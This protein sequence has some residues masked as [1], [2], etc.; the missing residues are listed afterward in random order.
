VLTGATGF[1]GSHVARLLVAQGHTVFAIIRPGANRWRLAD[2]ER[3]LRI[4]PG[5]LRDLSSLRDALRAARPEICVHLAWRGWSGQ[6]EAE[7]NLTSLG[8]S[9]D[10]LRMMPELSCGRFVNIGTCFEY[11]FSRNPQAE[12]TAL[13]PRE[14]YGTCKKSLFEVAQQF[15]AL[16]GV[17][18]VTP[19]VFFSYGPFEDVRRLVPSVALALL[20]GD[21]AKVTPGEQVRDYLHVEDVA[22][23]IWRVATSGIVGAVNIASAE[24]VTVADL[25]ARVGRILGKPELVRLGAIPY[26]PN[27]PMCI[28]GDATMLRDLLRWSPRFDLDRGLAATLSWWETRVQHLG[29]GAVS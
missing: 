18:V 4:I 13:R 9:L 29:H 20:R 23:A 24:P 21:V 2:I 15:S 6:A 3:E 14:L 17:S 8:V 26:R 10:L 7:E 5:D 12:T 19:R 11:D 28:V 16:T 1:I 22:S 25:T 27:E